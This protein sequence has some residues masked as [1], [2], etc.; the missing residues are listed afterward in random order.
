M[1]VEISHSNEI[2][3]RDYVLGEV[4]QLVAEFSN[5]APDAIQ[6]S[7]TL[8]GDLAFDS[9]DIVEFTMEIEEHFDI[10]IPDELTEHAKTVGN[11]VDGVLMLL[12]HGKLESTAL[13]HR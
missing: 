7:Q 3:S 9:L 8:L 11:V 10:S 4:R 1:S 6:E 2:I 13:D 12:N 5:V